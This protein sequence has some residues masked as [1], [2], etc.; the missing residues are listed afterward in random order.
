MRKLLLIAC[1]V[2]PALAAAQVAQVL[3]DYTHE[4]TKDK[5]PVF[6]VKMAGEKIRLEY[7]DKT[8]SEVV[9]LTKQERKDVWDALGFNSK[10]GSYE[11][12]E[13]V[14]AANEYICYLPKISRTQMSYFD[15]W[16]TD[17]FH[18]DKVLGVTEIRK[19]K[20]K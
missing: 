16:K 17:Y 11:H 6:S 1:L 12:A 13:C 5:R 18:Y 8:H 9:L 20:T 15:D 19:M 14:G 7:N 3:G 10:T 4:F 2:T